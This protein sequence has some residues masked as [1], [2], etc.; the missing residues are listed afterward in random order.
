MTTLAFFER[1]ESPLFAKERGKGQ[2]SLLVDWLESLLSLL[3]VYSP[4]SKPLSTRGG[5][6]NHTLPFNGF[7]LGSPPHQIFAQ[8]WPKAYYSQLYSF[9]TFEGKMHDEI[10]L[11][12]EQIPLKSTERYFNFF[13]TFREG[14]T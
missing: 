3:K 12:F 11:E 8:T 14:F 1:V 10:T 5:A 2:E 13:P 4:S 6:H 9:G 7:T